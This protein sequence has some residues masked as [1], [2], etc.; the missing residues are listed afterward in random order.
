[1]Q[2][3]PYAVCNG[4]VKKCLPKIMAEMERCENISYSVEGEFPQHADHRVV[5][6]GADSGPK[7]WDGLSKLR[8]KKGTSS[9]NTPSPRVCE[10]AAA[11]VYDSTGIV[12]ASVYWCVRVWE[13]SDFFLIEVSSSFLF[14]IAAVLFYFLRS[15]EPWNS[16]LHLVLVSVRLLQSGSLS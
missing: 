15:T 8:R 12:F 6:C 9:T 14:L 10:S 3:S 1:M 13:L 4:V 7:R 2:N 5:L 11:A 16:S